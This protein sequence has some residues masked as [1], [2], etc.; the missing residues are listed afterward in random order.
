RANPQ[1][2]AAYLGEE[3]AKDHDAEDSEDVAEVTEALSAQ[4]VLS[5][6]E[7]APPADEHPSALVVEN[8]SVHYG[9][10]VALSGVSFSIGAGRALAVLGANGAGKSSLARAVSGLVRPSDGRVTLD[11]QDTSHWAAYRVRRAGV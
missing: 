9:D 7:G 1:V 5:D 2:R 8:L 10:A 6:G 4:P 3:I 11:G